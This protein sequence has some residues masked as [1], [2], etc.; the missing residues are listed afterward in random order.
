M[1]QAHCLQEFLDGIVVSCDH[2]G[3]ILQIV[4]DVAQGPMFD[5]HPMFK[6]WTTQASPTNT[7]RTSRELQKKNPDCLDFLLTQLR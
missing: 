1:I 7:S 6:A 2:Q 3:E 5:V 4:K